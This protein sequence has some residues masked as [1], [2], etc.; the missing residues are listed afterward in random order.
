MYARGTNGVY[1]CKV[2]GCKVYMDSYM[3][4]KGSCVMVSL[5]ENVE[6]VR[7]RYFTLYM[8]EGPTEGVN[9]CKVDVKK[10]TWVPT[11]HPK[12]HVSW[13][14]GWVFKNHLLTLGECCEA[15]I[16]LIFFMLYVCMSGMYTKCDI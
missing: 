10:S 15:Y 16:V 9:E 11:W 8:L 7:V 3:A 1:E 12:G 4:S 13:S 6:P 5:V 2:G 14:L